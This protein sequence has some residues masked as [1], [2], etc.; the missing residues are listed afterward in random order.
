MVTG[1]YF[2]HKESVAK[3]LVVEEA[4]TP[5]IISGNA[6]DLAENLFRYVHIEASDKSAVKS[7]INSMDFIGFEVNSIKIESGFL[8]INYQVDSRTKYRFMDDYKKNFTQTCASLFVL[9][10]G[11]KSIHLTV[12]DNYGEFYSFSRDS[13]SL[14]YTDIMHDFTEEDFT[15]ASKSLNN[16]E[17]FIE[18]LLLIKT[19]TDNNIY[20]RQIYDVLSSNLQVV[21][22][23]KEQFVI[24][25]DSN[26]L[27]ILNSIGIN[28]Y[29][30]KNSSAELYFCNVEDYTVN[31]IKYYIFVFKDKTLISHNTISSQASYTDIIS[32]LK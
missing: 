29:K 10:D 26:K 8:L 7:L 3:K 28:L 20:L 2:A 13:R 19:D 27:A 5:S 6:K 16:F 18:K 9:V 25:L 24:A 11:L 17:L 12:S 1:G 22:G 4:P 14:L 31:E 21:D 23:T 32:L 30:H 15:S